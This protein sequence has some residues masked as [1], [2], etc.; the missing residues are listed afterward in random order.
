MVSGRLKIRSGFTGNQN[1]PFLDGQGLNNTGIL[2]LLQLNPNTGN[3][4]LGNFPLKG[5]KKAVQFNLNLAI[6]EAC[7][8]PAVLPQASKLN[9]AKS[10]PAGEDVVPL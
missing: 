10:R 9:V 7:P 2:P 5:S 4:G 3:Q 6:V 8:P 1:L